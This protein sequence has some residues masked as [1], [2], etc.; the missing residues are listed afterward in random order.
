MSESY[1]RVLVSDFDGTMTRHDFY[2]L[3]IEHLLPADTPNHWVDYRAERITHFEALRRYFAAIRS[4]EATVLQLIERMELD[5]QLAGAI[6]SLRKAGW[7]IVVASA[8]CR[9]YIDRLLGQAGVEI[10]VHGN[11]GR[12][13]AGAGL[14]MAM[15]QDSPFY[16]PTHGIN[17]RGIVE[18]FLN[19]G[20]EVAF[21]GDGFPDADAARLVPDDLRFARGDLASVLRKE[22]IPFQPYSMWSDIADEL[23]ARKDKP[24]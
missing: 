24:R 16:S 9:W 20:C 23:V 5:P 14:Q 13:E 17:K 7:R 10:E 15:P 18:H 21:A 8:G 4:D 11:P 1:G 6:A 12:F 3:A 19:S 22:G 2:Q